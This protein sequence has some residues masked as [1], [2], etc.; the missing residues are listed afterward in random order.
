MLSGD[1]LFEICGFLL[2]GGNKLF[3]APRGR[4]DEF[5]DPYFR[6]AKPDQVA[7]ILKAREP[8]RIMIAIGNKQDN[9]WH[10]QI[11]QRWVQQ[12]N[13][14]VNNRRWDRMKV[15]CVR[16]YEAIACCIP[17]IVTEPPNTA[18]NFVWYTGM[19]PTVVTTSL[20]FFI[21]ISIG[22]MIG[23]LACSSSVGSRPSQDAICLNSW[24]RRTESCFFALS[25]ESIA[26]NECVF[27]YGVG[28]VDPV[29]D[30][31]VRRL[32]TAARSSAASFTRA[33]PPG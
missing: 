5:V 25:E 33:H 14:Y 24:V 18:L 16:S 28:P 11:A 12:H 4:R 1:E 17:I 10:L 7:V 3:E 32:A 30:T 20:K 15:T 19:P 27:R 22:L 23:S 9:R 8:A 2:R 31:H 6:R 26:R 29:T 21:P 13:F